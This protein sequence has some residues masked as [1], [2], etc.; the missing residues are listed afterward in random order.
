MKRFPARF[1][2]IAFFPL[3]VIFNCLFFRHFFKTSY[4]D[5]YIANGALIS[6]VASL[7]SII[8][9]DL[10]DNRD[11][12]SAHPGRHLGANLKLLGS[13]LQVIG[14]NLQEAGARLRQRKPPQAND[15][16]TIYQ[17]LTARLSELFDN[18][19]GL[20]TTIF[21]VVIL[22]AWFIVMVPL[23]YFI[24]LFAGAPSRLALNLQ[25][26]TKQ[27]SGDGKEA[28]PSSNSFDGWLRNFSTMP[29]SLTSAVAALMI[30]AIKVFS[31]TA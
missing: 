20:A 3:M 9:K 4:I 1:F 7:F 21:I 24:V 18:I 13:H 25:D 5:W 19:A 10:N 8:W 6:L 17:T 27:P 30:F 28:P 15:S 22:A 29:V 31:D 14:F 2:C 16:H 26:Q 12:I 23:Q 11:L